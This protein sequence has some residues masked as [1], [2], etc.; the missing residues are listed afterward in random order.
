MQDDDHSN[1]H[2][3]IQPSSSAS[4]AAT[5]SSAQRGRR[6]PLASS[7][8]GTGYAALQNKD[9]DDDED[10]G[11]DSH[12]VNALDDDEE[13][14][15]S[16][17]VPLRPINRH[18]GHSEITVATPSLSSSSSSTSIPS[19]SS[20]YG[21]G[22]P[23][24]STPRRNMNVPVRQQ[25]RRM[26]QST[27]D[28]VFS[29]LSA[30]PRV[31]KPY[32]E[33]LPPP[34]KSAALDVSP[35]Y[36]ETTVM[37]P[38]YGDDEVLVD[39][40]PVGSM[41]GF[42][43]NMIISM[44]FQFVG[45]FLTYLL[46]TSHSTKNGSKMGLGVTFISMGW[47]MMNGKSALG[48]DDDDEGDSGYESDTGYISPEPLPNK[49]SETVAEFEWLSFLLMAMGALIM[50]QSMY[51]F[52][53]AKKTEMVIN[54]TSSSSLESGNG[55]EETVPGSAAAGVGGSSSSSSSAVLDGIVI[56]SSSAPSPSSSPMP[57]GVAPGSRVVVG[58]HDSI[59]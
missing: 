45:F 29:N 53:K 12:R 26:I 40:L 35:A 49:F 52:A 15:F 16:N 54:A 23:G 20:P 38:G 32:Q 56:V 18:T 9:D 42:M 14:S 17:S 21:N 25:A 5:S 37:A 48:N 58:T 41:F 59:V 27:M 34:Y 24:P 10:D 44:S 2:P 55:G 13:G 39:G 4:L 43:W 28:G 3:L 11:R 46:H 47:Q 30:K 1:N 36:Y 33:E 22:A 8:S 57:T 31:E 6:N 19:S 7:S 51:E 50:V